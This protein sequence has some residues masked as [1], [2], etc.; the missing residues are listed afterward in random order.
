MGEDH[1]ISQRQVVEQTAGILGRVHQ[2]QMPYFMASGSDGASLCPYD[3]YL[4][5]P[6]E[7]PLTSSVAGP[8]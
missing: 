4:Q 2:G 6:T 8:S 1:Y 7:G 5:W 3:V